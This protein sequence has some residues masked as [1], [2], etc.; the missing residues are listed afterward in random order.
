MTQRPD[1]APPT[2]TPPS[3]S[4]PPARDCRPC[5][6]AAARPYQTGSLVKA[7][8]PAAA[9]AAAAARARPRMGRLAARPASAAPAA[10]PP[11]LIALIHAWAPVPLPRVAA[12]PAPPT[13]AAHA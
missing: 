2:R 3:R 7:A 5:H 10:A 4:P 13:R 12:P 11:F 6:N 8:L 9:A 1:C